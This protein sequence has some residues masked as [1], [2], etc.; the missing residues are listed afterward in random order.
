[1]VKCLICGKEFENG[2]GPEICPTCLGDEQQE[3]KP[4]VIPEEYK[5]HFSSKLGE[6]DYD[7]RMFK[8]CEDSNYK[9]LCYK[10]SCRLQPYIPEGYN[11]CYGMFRCFRAPKG[12]T[13]GDNFD[14]SHITDMRSM[15][16]DCEFPEG[17]TLGDKFDTSNVTN[18]ACMF[19]N[20]KIPEGFTLGDKFDTSSVKDMANMFEDCTL[21]KGFSLGDKFDTSSVE[22]MSGMF[23]YCE[24]PEGFALGDKFDTSN[25]TRMQAM[26]MNCVLPKG[27]SLGDKFNTSRVTGMSYMFYGSSLSEGFSLGDKF[28]TSSV[29]NMYCMFYECSLPEGFTLGYKFDTSSVEDTQYMFDDCK[30]PRGISNELDALE[31]IELLKQEVTT[32]V[33]CLVCGKEF[34]NGFGPEICPKCLED[35]ETIVPEELTLNDLVKVKSSFPESYLYTIIVSIPDDL[36]SSFE[37]FIKNDCN[38]LSYEIDTKYSQYVNYNLKVALM[39][40]SKELPVFTE[41]Y[42]KMK[43]SGTDICFISGVDKIDKVSDKYVKKFI[44]LLNKAFNNQCDTTKNN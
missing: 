38:T 8:V 2:F 22:K 37:N 17:F 12:F 21:P 34:E 43:F 25:V 39:V 6:C 4:P 24:L 1:M 5:A 28:D 14:I 13:L 11:S 32:M 20:C 23:R 7:T 41:D 26:F 30:L 31:I 16:E 10:E 29:T 40:C 36:S 44:D 3:N 15:F 42:I 18:M 27:F 33:K 19:R 35:K 9:F